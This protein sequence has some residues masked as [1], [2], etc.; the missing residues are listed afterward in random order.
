MGSRVFHGLKQ[1]KLSQGTKGGRGKTAPSEFMRVPLDC[2]SD[3]DDLLDEFR[4]RYGEY[5]D[6]PRNAR[7]F[8]L[9]GRIDELLPPGGNL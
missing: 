1:W 9:L 6:S 8:E 5:P 3:L 7:L 2:V 4:E